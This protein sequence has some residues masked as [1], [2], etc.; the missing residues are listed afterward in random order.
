M[1]KRTPWNEAELELV[2][3]A[4]FGILNAE[5]A[6]EKV[7]KAAVRRLCLENMSK[8]G[9]GRSAGS[10]E[11]K[12][13]NISAAIL[14]VGAEL[15]LEIPYVNGYKPYGHGQKIM[16]DIIKAHYARFMMAAA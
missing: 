5:L 9:P 14:E 16:R 1:N 8:V 10:Y 11:M 3:N 12:C 15:E 2:M 7:N 13:M 6:G 4:Y